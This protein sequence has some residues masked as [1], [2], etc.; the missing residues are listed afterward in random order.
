MQ[1]ENSP[2]V[3]IVIPVYNGA[4]Y[5]EETIRSV[6][7]QTISNIEVLVINDASKDES[8]AIIEKIQ[9]EDSRVKLINKQNSGVAA[10]R[11]KGLEIAKGKYIAFLDQDDVWEPGNLEEKIK[12][13]LAEK[14]SWA[15]SNISYIDATGKLI[16]KEEKIVFGDFYRNLLKWE[17]VIPAPS[18]N[19]VAV[20]DF[21]HTDIRYDVNIPYP[22]DRD[23]CVQLARKGEPSFVNKKLWRYRIHGE[24]MSAVNK[25]ITIEMAMMYE[26]Y[27]RD[28][29]FPD[30]TTKKTALSRVYLMIAGICLKFTKERMKG[31][32]F[33]A[34][35][36]FASPA[37]FT[38]NML[39]RLK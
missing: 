31:I 30:K 32:G 38:K 19:I 13:M 34:K 36:F 4:K 3:S 27:K 25:R 24:S 10:T 29:Y 16:D 9:I 2:L 18:G 11:N 20:R 21:L 23:F 5:I 33:M 39:Q 22:S 17:N 12:V 7:A 15:F 26:K 14:R 28:N 35:S 6:L 1:Q 37:Y 8:A